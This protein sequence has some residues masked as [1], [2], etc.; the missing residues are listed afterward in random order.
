MTDFDRRLPL[1]V[2]ALFALTAAMAFIVY[3]GG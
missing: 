1:Y 3:W 2:I